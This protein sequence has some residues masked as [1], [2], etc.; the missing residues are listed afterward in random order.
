MTEEAT[1]QLERDYLLAGEEKGGLILLLI[2]LQICALKY[3][4][5]YSSPLDDSYR[6]CLRL[7]RSLS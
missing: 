5:R 2:D 1:P 7:L 4:V 3:G 6:P